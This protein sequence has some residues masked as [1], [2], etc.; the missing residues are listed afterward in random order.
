MAAI[1]LTAYFEYSRL[2]LFNPVHQF[3]GKSTMRDG[4]FEISVSSYFS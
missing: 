2:I 1:N 4:G 3:Q